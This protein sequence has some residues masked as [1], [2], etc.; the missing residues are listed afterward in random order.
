MLSRQRATSGL[1][2][3][4]HSA[5]Q[6]LS[7]QS[8]GRLSAWAVKKPLSQLF[9]PPASIGSAA[10]HC[11]V[12]ESNCGTFASSHWLHRL[13]TGFHRAAH[14]SEHCGKGPALQSA[15]LQHAASSSEERPLTKAAQSSAPP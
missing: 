4:P 1:T 3:A 10:R 5:E 15:V 13:T 7:P 8:E 12:K 6:P 9:P 11:S 2:V 14:R